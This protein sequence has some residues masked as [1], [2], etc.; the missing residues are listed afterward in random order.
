MTLSWRKIALTCLEVKSFYLIGS[1][2]Q[3][4]LIFQVIFVLDKDHTTAE[5]RE[6]FFVGGRRGVGSTGPG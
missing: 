1:E 3:N 6:R 4:Y 5:T 2:Y